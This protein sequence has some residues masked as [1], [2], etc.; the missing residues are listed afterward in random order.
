MSILSLSHPFFKVFYTHFLQLSSH[1]IELHGFFHTSTYKPS[2]FFV[3]SHRISY[4]L[5]GLIV[6]YFIGY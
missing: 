6:T 4:C 3:Y 2:S 1:L 5:K